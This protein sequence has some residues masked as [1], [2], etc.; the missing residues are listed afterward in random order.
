MRDKILSR[1]KQIEELE[2]VRVLFACE[3]G[4]R[5]WGF[6]SQDSDFDIRFVYVRPRDWYLSIEDRRDVIELPI[7]GSLDVSGW[8]LRK[9][10]RLFRQSNPP[11]LEWLRSPIV[12]LD[13][14][15]VAQ[16]LRDLVPVYFSPK[17]CLH[18]YLHMAQGNYREYL[19]GK[20]VHLKKYF[21]V[22]R[23]VLA[24][25]WIEAKNTMPPT[26]FQALVATHVEDPQLRRA[27]DS[28]LER[29][30]RGD[31]L[32]R[33]SRIQPIND[34][35]QAEIARLTEYVR[36]IERPNVAPPEHLDQLFRDILTDVQPA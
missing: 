4:S 5:A 30:V 19:Q 9:A 15:G 33:G 20:H 36:T 23:P 12:Y 6:P 28:L 1:L 34:F 21:Y 2:H 17:S 29:K 25:R 24:C 14:H 11:L 22:L 16:R 3:S 32:D 26:E 31:E 18:H 8:D 13:S 10:L 27:I 7:D 35:L